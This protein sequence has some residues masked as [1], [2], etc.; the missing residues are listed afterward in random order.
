MCYE[1]VFEDAKGDPIIAVRGDEATEGGRSL[2]IGPEK[3]AN[4]RAAAQHCRA[5][6]A[7]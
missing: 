4:A 6:K 3:N 2:C 7:H 1:P 5:A